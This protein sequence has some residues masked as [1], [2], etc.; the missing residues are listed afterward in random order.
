MRVSHAQ[1]ARQRFEAGVIHLVEIADRAIGDG[2]DAAQ[3]AMGVAVHLAPE[4]ADDARL[5][6]ILHYND[7]RP[8]HARRDIAGIRSRRSGFPRT[9]RLLGSKTTVTA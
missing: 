3:C 9:S 1:A 4:G 5:V 6:E 2:A 7:L 8:G